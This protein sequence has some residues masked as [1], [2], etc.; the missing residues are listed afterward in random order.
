MMPAISRLPFCRFICGLFSL[1]RWCGF[2]GPIVGRFIASNVGLTFSSFLLGS[3]YA[4][5]SWK[6]GV[7]TGAALATRGTAR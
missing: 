3:M 2:S 6:R 4:R 1:P 5:N 7:N